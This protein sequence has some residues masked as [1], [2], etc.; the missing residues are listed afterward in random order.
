M[1]SFLNEYYHARMPFCAGINLTS[2]DLD[3]YQKIYFQKSWAWWV[4]HIGTFA[5]FVIGFFG[6]LL[7]LLVL[8]RGLS[9]LDSVNVSD[10]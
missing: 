5:V 3:Y 7:C 10:R 2:T 1:D 9:T 6:N 8:C 4:N